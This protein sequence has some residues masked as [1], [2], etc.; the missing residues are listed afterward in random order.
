MSTRPLFC[1]GSL[2]TGLRYE[3]Q[4]SADSSNKNKELPTKAPT[5]KPIL[6]HVACHA[7]FFLSFITV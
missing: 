3:L 5:V 6:L 4:N 2:K 1:A 7:T